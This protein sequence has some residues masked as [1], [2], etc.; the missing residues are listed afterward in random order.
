MPACRFCAA[1]LRLTAVDLGMS[2]LAESF[3][4]ADETRW[5]ERFYPLHVLLCERCYL[6]QLEAF[7]SPEEIFTEYAYFASYSSSWVEHA[8]S[9]VDAIRTRLALGRDDLVVELASNDGYLLQHFVGTGI[10]F[11]GVDPAANVAVAA[12]KRGVPTLV[13]F[14]GSEIA[15]ELTSEG[16]CA[17]LVIANNVLAQ[18][19]NLNDFV[20][21]VKILLQEG[22]TATFELPHLGRLLDGVQYDRIYHEHFSYFSFATLAEVLRAH[23]L[24]VYDVEELSTHGGSLRVYAQHVAGP[25]RI[26]EAVGAL[27]ARE[28]AQGLRSRER[29]ERFAEDV[30]ESKR[31][32]LE[33]LIELRRAGKHVVGYGAPGKATTLLN[34]CG[35]RTDLLDYTVDRSPYKQGLFTPGTHI[36]IHAPEMIA[37]TRPDYVV[38]FPWNLIDEISVQLSFVRKWGGRLIVPIPN[39]TIVQLTPRRTRAKSA[40]VPI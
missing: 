33:L 14:F 20:A 3:L 35:I 2:P 13:R 28:Q 40:E 39:A 25:H 12:E 18:I 27:L 17:S 37:D 30:K 8:R 31:A 11:L 24:D 23:E 4:R 29:Y 5:P 32:L 22:G 7:V 10:P 36:P 16:R 21:G 34:Y 26:A 38:V 9:Y 19:P 15:S 1:P 6:L